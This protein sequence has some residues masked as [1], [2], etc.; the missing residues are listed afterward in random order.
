MVGRDAGGLGAGGMMAERRE[1]LLI[2]C[3]IGALVAVI[4]VLALI[5]GGVT[6]GKHLL[7]DPAVDLVEVDVAPG[8]AAG[9]EAVSPGEAVD[10]TAEAREPATIAEAAMRVEP[11]DVLEALEPS[12]TPE[13]VRQH[14]AWLEAW[15]VRRDA[16]QGPDMGRAQVAALDEARE[17]LVKEYGG[18][19][20]VLGRALRVALASAAAQGMALRHGRPEPWSDEVAEMM[21]AQHEEVAA[22]YAEFIDATRIFY[23]HQQAV[24][25]SGGDQSTL[26]ARREEGGR[27]MSLPRYVKIAQPFRQWPGLAA[28][29][30]MSE[31]AVG[32]WRG[33]SAEE[34][35]A[36]VEQHTRLPLPP[37]LD[38]LRIQREGLEQVVS[39][40]E[41][42]AVRREIFTRVHG[43]QAV[44]P[45]AP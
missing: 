33:L 44:V 32:T 22:E 25:G 15:E 21:E 12:L 13:D 40:A 9:G 20:A 24:K 23:E 2:G 28:L 38:F 31:A 41:H 42:D 8:E 16:L 39:L 14:R 26:R 37:S 18:P 35:S 27:E 45:P 34:R 10:G 11:V 1:K 36:I 7:G 5:V 3:S 4:A 30:Q 29:G 17:A 43:S 19:K 6:A